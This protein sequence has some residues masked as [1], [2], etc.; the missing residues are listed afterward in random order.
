LV[1]SKDKKE[2]IENG[3]KKSYSNIEFFL[4]TVEGP[5][6]NEEREH[7]GNGEF[8]RIWFQTIQHCVKL[9]FSQFKVVTYFIL[10]LLSVVMKIIN[11]F[12]FKF[13][14]FSIKYFNVVTQSL[15]EL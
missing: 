13:D 3:G 6:S 8:V 5:H 1:I 2:T 4:F 9:G 14:L 12:L 11:I 7:N 15:F 10:I